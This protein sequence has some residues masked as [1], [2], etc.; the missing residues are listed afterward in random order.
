MDYNISVSVS[1]FNTQCNSKAS[2]NLVY[3]ETVD[4]YQL[5]NELNKL[6]KQS[7]ILNPQ[8]ETLTV[9]EETNV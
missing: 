6:F 7:G 1:S 5:V 2:V 9:K 3:Y 4:I 8:N